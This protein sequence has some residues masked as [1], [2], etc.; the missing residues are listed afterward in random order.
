MTEGITEFSER[1]GHETKTLVGVNFQIDLE[2][3]GFPILSLR[4]VPVKMFVAE[5][6]VETWLMNEILI[7]E[8]ANTDTKIKG[9]KVIGSID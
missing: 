2:K 5:H 1:T 7:V 4:K 8:I 3:D 6:M 9:L